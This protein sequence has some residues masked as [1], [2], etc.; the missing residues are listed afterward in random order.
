MSRP[1]NTDRMLGLG[2]V[3]AAMAVGGMCVFI[4]AF[5]LS[6]S[7]SAWTEIG[8]WRA[9]ADASWHPTPGSEGTFS[10][11]SAIV[12]TLLASLL[13]TLLAAPV[14]IAAACGAEFFAPA[15]VR[16]TMDVLVGVLAGIPSVVLGLWGITVLVPIIAGWRPPGTSLLAAALTL[17][18]MIVPTVY[19]MAVSSLRAIPQATLDAARCTGLSDWGILRLAAYP[20]ARGGLALAVVLALTRAMGETMAVVMV[21]GNIPS[22]PR[23]VLDPVRT[24]TGNIALE[25]PYATGLHRSMLFASGVGLML[26]VAALV[27]LTRI[28][29]RENSRA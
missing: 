3:V 16:R 1:A 11:L 2:S 10:L 8:L 6:R 25:M 13:G 17:A 5:L 12:G 27:M 20:A 7:S 24:L 19:V 23:S 9:L 22:M 18:V 28:I 29:A 4:A 21:A 15:V 14:G 26:V